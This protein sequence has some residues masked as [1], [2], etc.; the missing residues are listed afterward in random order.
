MQAVVD[1]VRLQI[2]R[3]SSDCTCDAFVDCF[4][5]DHFHALIGHK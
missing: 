1:L 2:L 4:M 5:P 3:T